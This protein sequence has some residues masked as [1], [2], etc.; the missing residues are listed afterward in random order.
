MPLPFHAGLQGVALETRAEFQSRVEHFG[1]QAVAGVFHVS[2]HAEIVGGNGIFEPVF[3]ANVVG[4]LFARGERRALQGEESFRIEMMCERGGAEKRS[5]SVLFLAVEIN[6][7]RLGIFHRAELRFALL[8][9]E[10]VAVVAD[11]A[12]HVERPP[13]VGSPGKERLP[14]EEVRAVFGIGV[15]RAEQV[16]RGLVAQRGH[17]AHVLIAPAHVAAGSERGS[18]H[19][20]FKLLRTLVGDV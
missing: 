13:L 4:L 19:R 15:E 14:V 3:A 2:A 16:A 20:G 6:L 10:I 8:G 12:E 11:V 17:K 9:H 7:E 18:L 1:T 5:E